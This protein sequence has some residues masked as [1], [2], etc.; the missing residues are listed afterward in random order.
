[1]CKIKIL[2]VDDIF[3]NLQIIENILEEN[4]FEC[5]LA[6]NG[7]EA[8]QLSISELPELIL[9]D[10]SMPELDGYET[11]KR[12]KNNEL[13]KDIPIIFLSALNEV[14]SIT[15]GFR[16]GGVDY[17]IKPFNVDELLA[18]ILTHL[19]LKKSRDT[20]VK[21]NEYLELQ[22]SNI[23]QQHANILS[24]IRY[25]KF[26]QEAVLPS[27]KF[28][29]QFLP[30]HFVIY[31]PKENVSGDFYRTTQ[32]QN[33]ILFVVADCTGHG[34][35]GAFMSML[36][37]A[38]LMEITYKYQ[39]LVEFNSATVLN[40]LRKRIKRTLHQDR[41]KDTIG[42]GMDLALCIIDIE[43][44]IMNYSGAK[45][46][47]YLVRYNEETNSNQLIIYKPD[48]MPIAVYLVEQPFTNHEIQLHTNDLIYLFSDGY[49]DQ[50]GGAKKSKL[51][52]SNFKNIILENSYKSM[53]EQESKLLSF[54]KD[55][56]GENEQ[57]DDVLLI[58]IKISELY[59]DVSFFED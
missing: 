1:M 32:I 37:I 28:L 31:I 57:T 30:E 7:N 18:R 22:K 16:S 6:S 20:I 34:V 45:I 29:N 49:I 47:L 23:E 19:E 12:I 8:I 52:S 43:T 24:S 54:F 55:W 39:S 48:K 42:D 53:H 14:E 11:C 9:L 26:I 50:F 21:Q 5:I 56:K 58:G 2:A 51:L 25:A 38:F 10:I 13:T 15:K 46:P 40:Q 27:E 59:G 17:V 3:E 4:N 44:K 33:K 36:G 41:R 35:P